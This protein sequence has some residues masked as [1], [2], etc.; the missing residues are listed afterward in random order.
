MQKIF[1]LPLFLYLLSNLSYASSV[2]IKTYKFTF[3]A[4]DNFTVAFA[5]YPKGEEAFYE[6]ESKAGVELPIF[7]NTSTHA[8]KVCGINHSDDLFMYAYKK[9]SGLKPNTKYKV[10]F[11]LEFASKALAGSSGVGG[12]PG[13]SVYVKIGALS[14][15]PA[16]YVDEDGLYRVS[17]DKG[18]QASDGKDMIVIGD[19]GVENKKA[20]YRLKTL[21]YNPDPEMQRKI[22]NYTVTT[23]AQGEIW[24]V[25]GTDSGFEGRSRVYYTNL[26]VGLKVV[27]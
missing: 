9:L 12:S 8:L 18:N 15:E 20:V 3:E 5:D 19:I 1:V 11:S 21:P 14:Q 2:D 7:I 22:D 26:V 17:W 16:R 13:D 24:V 27:V 25:F 23:N 4:K 6:L 10:N